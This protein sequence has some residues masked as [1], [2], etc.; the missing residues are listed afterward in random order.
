MN[1]PLIPL[2]Q[3]PGV[4]VNLIVRHTG[5]LTDTEIVR[6]A[7]TDDHQIELCDGL[8]TSNDREPGA[9]STILR[10]LNHGELSGTHVFHAGCGNCKN[11]GFAHWHLAISGD[12]PAVQP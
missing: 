5:D 11:S 1:H 12:T 8:Y 2:L 3:C 10:R 4:H 9:D 7:A 6:L